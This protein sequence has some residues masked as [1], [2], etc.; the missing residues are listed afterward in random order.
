M[1]DLVKYEIDG[2]IAT[3]TF[4]NGK[5][6]A[7]SPDHLTA[8]DAALD[9]AEAAGAVVMLVGQPGIFSAGFDLKVFQKDPKEGVEMVTQGSKLCRRLQSFPTPVVGVCTGHAIA[10]G[11]FT[12]LSCDY[13]IGVAG[14]FQLG[15]NEV[16]IGMTMHHAGIEMARFRLTPSFF[17]RSVINAEMYDPAMAVTAGFLDKIVPEEDLMVAAKAEATRLAGLNLP[18]HKASKLKARAAQLDALDQAIAT[19][20]KDQMALLGG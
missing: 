7:M 15:L 11:C 16:Q 8:I 1:S 20:H 12:L 17:Q 4:Q 10:Q 2:N 9:K 13:R 5:V 19:D 14:P 6:N 18:A 3:I